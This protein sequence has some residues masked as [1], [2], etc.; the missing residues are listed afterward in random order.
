MAI[1]VVIEPCA[2]GPPANLFVV[3]ARL[4]R[5][6]SKRSISIV[7]K[8]DVLSPEAAEKIVPAIV[9]IVPDADAGLPSC[10]RQTRFL[11]HIGERAVAIVF[12]EVRRG[13][14]AR[15]PFGIQPRPVREIDV[16]PAVVIVIEKSQATSFCFDDRLLT[17]RSAPYVGRGESRIACDVNKSHRRI[18]WRLF[19]RLQDCGTPSPQGSG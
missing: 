3:H 7:V 5:H 19:C 2:P 1:S 6:I 14:L 17:F 4:A 9:V 13:G 16:E 15:W 18:G 11:G 8:Q 10:S 12:V